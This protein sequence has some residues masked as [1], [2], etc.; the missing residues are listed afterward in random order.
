[1]T[2]PQQ[3]FLRDRTVLSKLVAGALVSCDDAGIVQGAGASA[4]VRYDYHNHSV[5]IFKRHNYSRKL[6]PSLRRR[7]S[8]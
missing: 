8:Y 2:L 7:K 4:H 6:P 1:M 5:D 3:I